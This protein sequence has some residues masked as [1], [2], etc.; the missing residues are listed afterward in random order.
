[1]KVRKLLAESEARYRALV[2][3]VPMITYTSAIDETST[4]LYI[5]PQVE[6]ILGYT[7]KEYL[8]DPDIWYKLLHPLDRERV[9]L[10]VMKSH[11]SGKPF[12]SEY[13]MRSRTGHDVW[14]LDEAALVRD[15]A[16]APLCLQGIMFDITERKH[17]E[18]RIID[19]LEFNQR[20]FETSPVGI[21]VYEVS[22][23]C[24]S[25]NKTAAR[26]IGISPDQLRKQNFYQVESWKRS[27]LLETAMAALREGIEKD[28]RVNFVTASGKEIRLDCRFVPFTSLS[29][30]H[31]L[32]MFIDTPLP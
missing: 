8:A 10:E 14:I 1:M 15:D 29:V 13:R 5:S 21:A 19:A 26:I 9:L 23:K 28:R 3:Q 24:V 2:E 22:G 16:G 27:G 11:R 18:Q 31:L 30:Q 7:Q 4:T 25:A 17:M 12:A 6:K 20:I 32:L